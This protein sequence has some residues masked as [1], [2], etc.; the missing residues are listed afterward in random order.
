MRDRVIWASLKPLRRRTFAQ[1]RRPK[2]A[3]RLHRAESL[4]ARRLLNTDPIVTVNTNYGSFQIQTLPSSAPNTVAN[5][6]SYVDGNDYTNAVYHRSVPGFVEQTGGY[7]SS[8]ATFGG[9]TS[10]FTPIVQHAAI[11]LEYNVPNTRGTVAMARGTDPNS[12][13]NQW[14]VNL[15]DNSQTLGP[16]NS[17]G[18]AVFGQVLDGGMSVL[19]QVAALPTSNID[20][21]TF[22]QLPLGPN[23]TLVRISSITVDNIDGTV[24][25]DTNGNGQLDA[26]EPPLTGRR[27]FVDVDGSG[28]LD[29]NNP[30]TTTD[31][32]GNF[33]FTGIA[34]GRYTV[35]EVVPSGGTLTTP[36]Q[37]VS[38]AADQTASGVLFGERPSIV[39][40]VFIDANGNGHF[41]GGE[42]PA[43]GR[44]VFVDIDGSGA[45]DNNNPSTTTD[46]NGNFSFTSLAPGTYTV[47][48]QVPSGISLTTPAPTVAVT[49]GQT[50][51][52]VDLGETAPP[53]TAN[54]KFVAQVFRDLLGRAAEP[55]ALQYWANQIEGGQSRTA[56]TLAIEMSQ[57]YRNDLVQSLYEQ[58]LH[59]PADPA[60]QAAGGAVLLSGGTPEQ[61]SLALVSSNEYFQNRAS[62]SGTGFVNALYSDALHRQADP[63]V[64]SFLATDD[65]TNQAVRL[66]VAQ[67]VFS[68]DEFLSDLISLPGASAGAGAT[69]GWYQL[70]LGRDADSASLAHDVQLLHGG[71][72]DM[73]MVA[74]IV[75]SDEYYARATT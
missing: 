61:L 9:S 24:F 28:T 37:T 27:V 67:A 8:L 64:Q 50:V 49:V 10:Q 16:S 33:S 60:G 52:G 1:R 19:D 32:N 51:S 2:L 26:G 7:T 71:Q 20:N 47:R 40:T 38:V 14:F 41:D 39:G 58:Y 13:T 35:R 62:G 34:P 25:S 72:T 42:L 54:Q 69:Q 6:L 63:A 57:E 12:A 17:G 48:D 23:S 65:F 21:G 68:S 74:E 70:Y 59:R 30:S 75:A 44:T 73:Q 45:P 4:E 43:V 46:A 55:Q 18:Y 31:A 29:S 3:V 22:S 36:V 66:Q 5:F 11:P 56:T 15:A 53:L